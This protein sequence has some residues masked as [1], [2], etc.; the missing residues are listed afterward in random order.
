L[1]GLTAAD[2]LLAVPASALLEM[3]TCWIA[4]T[5]CGELAPGLEWVDAP[6]PTL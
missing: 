6:Q 4:L 3:L 5:S 2:V 1:P